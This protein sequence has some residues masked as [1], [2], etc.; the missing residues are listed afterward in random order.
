M[1]LLGILFVV[2]AGGAIAIFVLIATAIAGREENRGPAPPPPRDA[3]AAS[4]L[5][6]I[7][8]CGGSTVEE[9]I[10]T[11]R[12]GVGLAAPVTT[13]I[14]VANWAGSF[15]RSATTEQRHALLES[16]VRLL[17]ARGLV[18]VRQ[19]AALLDLSFGL[20]FQTDALARLRAQYRFEYVDHAE[21]G[22]PKGEDRAG[23]GAPLFVRTP[24]Q[25]ATLLHVLGVSESA[26]RQELGLAYR[27]LVLQH[28]P[29]RYHGASPEEQSA[30]AAKFIEITRAYEELLL[31]Q[32]D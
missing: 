31:Q 17:S 18:P 26:T 11:V 27:K 4:L 3:V 25:K 10:R 13:G 14:D 12:R 6:Q 23:D 29:D 7:I 5:V 1:E 24:R 16:A 8:V 2:G 28:H 9:A 20:G 32:P 15:A 22:R 19:Y 30:A 21:E